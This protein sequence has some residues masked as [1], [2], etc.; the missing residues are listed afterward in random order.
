MHWTRQQ[1]RLAYVVVA[2]FFMSWNFRRFLLSISPWS[3]Q[4]MLPS[5]LIAWMVVGLSYKQEDLPWEVP[6]YFGLLKTIPLLPLERLCR[7][8]LTSFTMVLLIVFSFTFVFFLKRESFKELFTGNLKEKIDYSYS[9]PNSWLQVTGLFI[10]VFTAWFFFKKAIIEGV[11]PLISLNLL[12]H[13]FLTALYTSLAVFSIPIIF[14]RRRLDREELLL[15]LALGFG[16]FERYFM[17]GSFVGTLIFLAI[18]WLLART[19][20]ETRGSLLSS[21][22]IF[23]YILMVI[24]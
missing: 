16:L 6:L 24:L 1:R 11:I 4:Y 3:P 7:G 9:F 8:N 12:Q 5:I 23:V 13:A 21:L 10:L 22:M 15:G 2:F 19:S 20:Y 14:L 17:I 18:G